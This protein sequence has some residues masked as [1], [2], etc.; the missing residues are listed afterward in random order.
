V[1]E[2]RLSGREIATHLGITRNT[3]CDWL[4]HKKMPAHRV[5]RLWKFQLSKINEW[6]RSDGAAPNAGHKGGAA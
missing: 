4:A 6:V 1:A 3:G 5:G 2:P